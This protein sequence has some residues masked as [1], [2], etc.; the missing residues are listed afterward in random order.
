MISRFQ[1]LQS[2]DFGELALSKTYLHTPGE[3]R[4]GGRE[5]CKVSVPRRKAQKQW[6]QK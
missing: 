6:R 5:C 4:R 1:Q 2:S 3:E